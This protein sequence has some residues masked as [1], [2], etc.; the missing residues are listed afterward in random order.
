[1]NETF[2]EW[3]MQ[4]AP[5][6]D[7]EETEDTALASQEEPDAEAHDAAETYAKSALV[8]GRLPYVPEPSMRWDSARK[9]Y[10]PVIPG[11]AYGRQKI[12]F[13]DPEACRLF[14]IK[15]WMQRWH[16][17][18]VPH[19]RFDRR[20]FCYNFRN[21]ADRKRYRAY[22]A[23]RDGGLLGAPIVISGA[24]IVE[25]IQAAK[26]ALAETSLVPENTDPVIAPTDDGRDDRRRGGSEPDLD[27]A[28]HFGRIAYLTRGAYKPTTRSA[29]PGDYADRTWIVWA[30]VGGDKVQRLG[31]FLTDRAARHWALDNGFQWVDYQNHPVVTE[32]DFTAPTPLLIDP[33]VLKAAQDRLHQPQR[34]VAIRAS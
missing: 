8:E 13:D 16:R 27:V 23:Q 30:Y 10:C 15:T 34:L 7:A 33:A 19:V 2:T 5:E 3:W 32:E 11:T 18:H 6:T 26:P 25:T 29:E 14:A 21:P 9:A 31:A 12:Y 28:L 17:T 24:T 20:L 4:V 22:Y 1:M